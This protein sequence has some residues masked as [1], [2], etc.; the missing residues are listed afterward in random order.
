MQLADVIAGELPQLRRFAR[1]LAGRQD[2][3][4]QAVGEF[5][6]HLVGGRIT[7]LPTTG[8][9]GIYR[10]F[11]A[12]WLKSISQHQDPAIS[13]SAADE[14]LSR[15]D[16]QLRCAFLLDALEQFSAEDAAKIMNVSEPDYRALLN[17]ASTT[18]AK[19]VATSVLIIEDELLIAMDLES[20]MND[21]GH[22]VIG[23]ATTRKEALD[24]C[25]DNLPGLILSDIHLADASSGIE[26]VNDILSRGQASVVFITAFPE[27][28]LS[29]DRAE[30]PF[31][32]SKPFRVREVCAVVS[33]ALFFAGPDQKGPFHDTRSPGT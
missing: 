28:L 31:L 7:L 1:L 32:I 18:I 4:D 24:L 17:Q 8:R 13:L 5:L 27:R 3:A 21:L 22:R 15:L 14:R 20:I 26:A 30:P 23:I 25:K 11:V 10:E 19:Q 6:E 12:D 2:F 9:A 33:Q 16:G 29:G